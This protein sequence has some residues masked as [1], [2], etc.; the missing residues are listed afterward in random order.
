MIFYGPGI[1]FI[2]L[3]LMAFHL[4]AIVA[5]VIVRGVFTGYASTA[6]TCFKQS[7]E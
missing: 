1:K 7:I 6:V 4:A 5:E 2:P 3:D